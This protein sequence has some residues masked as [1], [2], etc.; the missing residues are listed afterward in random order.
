[1]AEKKEYKFTVLIEPCVEDG[2][3]ATCPAVPGC[4]VEG[5]TYEETLNEMRLAIGAFVEDYKEEGEEIPEE[6]VTI[7]TLRVAI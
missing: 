4:H 1:M 6:G 7:A 2:Y 3:F 5:E